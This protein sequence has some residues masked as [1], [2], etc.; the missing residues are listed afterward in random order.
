MTNFNDILNFYSGEHTVLQ[1]RI[2]RIFLSEEFLIKMDIYIE[3]K[4][5]IILVG[6]NKMKCI[7]EDKQCSVLCNQYAKCCKNR[8][9]GA[10]LENNK[11]KS[12]STIDTDDFSFQIAQNEYRIT[13]LDNISDELYEALSDIIVKHPLVDDCFEYWSSEL[14]LLGVPVDN[15]VRLMTVLSGLGNVPKSR[16]ILIIFMTLYL[17]FIPSQIKRYNVEKLM[18]FLESFNYDKV[19]LS[20]VIMILVLEL[21][22]YDLALELYDLYFKYSSDIKS[23]VSSIMTLSLLGDD[24]KVPDNEVFSLGDDDILVSKELKK[25]KGYLKKIGCTYS[26][27]VTTKCYN[28]IMYTDECLHDINIMNHNSEISCCLNF[29]FDRVDDIALTY[30]RYLLLGLATAPSV[31]ITLSFIDNMDIVS[32]FNKDEY[33]YLKVLSCV[34]LKRRDIK[35]SELL[36]ND[37]SVSALIGIAGMFTLTRLDDMCSAE[38]EDKEKNIENS[39][40]YLAYNF[41]NI[42]LSQNIDKKS[43]I[44]D[45]IYNNQITEAISSCALRDNFICNMIEDLFIDRNIC[46]IYKELGVSSIE[47]L[48][49]KIFEGKQDKTENIIPILTDIYDIVVN[50][51]NFEG[52]KIIN[53]KYNSV[54]YKL[55][56]TLIID[57]TNK[58]RL[59]LLGKDEHI[60]PEN[61]QESKDKSGV[62]PEYTTRN[63]KD[64]KGD[65]FICSLI[66][67]VVSDTVK[68]IDIMQEEI[69]TKNIKDKINTINTKLDLIDTDKIVNSLDDMQKSISKNI[70]ECLSNIKGVTNSLEKDTIIELFNADSIL[71]DI[72]NNMDII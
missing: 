25:Y 13:H 12:Y 17:R 43:L 47:K 15:S 56:N 44:Y 48:C 23:N 31:I 33:K 42:M 6:G 55:F 38:I 65:T 2:S 46:S 8:A 60:E 45:I 1:V 18:N 61:T 34:G 41:G 11:N 20:C 22:D 40:I 69:Y 64:K 5:Y 4:N 57:G 30:S 53:S 67:N 49:D 58:E 72:N 59:L 63:Q 14:K 71:N 37:I 68:S 9:N 27:T 19:S 39:L 28:N 26:K 32:I 51:G 54:I 66:V 36:K 50:E 52:N 35:Y 16:T 3:G 29:F 21:E 7:Y 24:L 10:I 62:V 70:D